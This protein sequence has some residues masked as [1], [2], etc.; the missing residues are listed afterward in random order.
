MGILPEAK[1]FLEMI[2]QQG[3]PALHELEPAVAREATA[4]MFAAL[5]L[6]PIDL[7]KIEDLEIP[8]PDGT[9]PARLYT[10]EAASGP[11]PVLAYFHG[12]G[13]ALGGVE[14]S[15][16][17]CRHM[18]QKLG[19][20]VVSVEY[21]KPPEHVF[22]AAY[23]DCLN[24]TN[25][26]TSAPEELGANVT[27]VVISGDSA[28][29]N[30]AAAISGSGKAQP[31]AQLL[32]YPILDV[33]K[34]SGSYDEFAEGYFLEKATMNWFRDLYLGGKTMANDPRVSPLLATDLSMVPPTV[35]T[36]CEADVLRDEGRAYAAKLVQQ[37]GR[38]TYREA[39][40]LIHGIASFRQIL[41]TGAIEV[42]VAL[43]CLADL[44]KEIG[45][46]PA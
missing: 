46:M 25:W 7:H 19:I 29:G 36:T 38:V 33:S 41:P 39:K 15:D 23:D 8:G 5:D 22:P 32:L 34:H 6:P 10:P 1:A 44:L 3:G 27:A 16:S 31:A 45:V 4:P 37:G 28:G 20:R 9:I 21:R 24:A 13:W 26:I 2:A 35:I 30:V 17:F 14:V 43:D 11:G 42:D 12:G 40:G 18:A